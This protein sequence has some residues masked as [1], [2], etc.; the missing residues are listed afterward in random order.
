MTIR[1]GRIWGEVFAVSLLLSVFGRAG[2][3]QEPPLP[4]RLPPLE[5]ISPWTPESQPVT[6][7][8]STR[9]KAKKKR[10]SSKR[11]KKPTA[12]PFIPLSF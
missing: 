9:K 2:A 5:S 11:K 3:D 10:R 4:D 7:T 6:L 1:C 8:K 12:K